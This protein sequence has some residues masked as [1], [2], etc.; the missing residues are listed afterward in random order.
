MRNQWDSKK[1]KLLDAFSSFDKR[2]PM[3]AE[4]MHNGFIV[5]DDMFID[6]I[7]EGFENKFFISVKNKK[8]LVKD[9]SYNKRRKQKSLA[10]YCEYAGSNFIQLSG[11][12]PCQK[13]YLGMYDNR[14]VVLCEDLFSECIFRPFKELHQSSAGTDLG[15]KEYTY[16]DVLYVLEKKEKLVGSEFSD[17]K[18]KFW[19]MFLFD[20]ILGNRDRHEGN[21]G[22]VKKNSKT[23]LAPIF[24][25][26]SSLFPDVDL[27]D[28]KHYQFVK[29]RVHKIPASQFKMWKPG[30]VDRP[31]RTNFYEIIT[32]FHK[33]FKDELT[34]VGQIDYQTIAADSIV[35]VPEE[36]AEWFRVIIECR[37]RVL[38]LGEDFDNVWED[39]ARRYHYD[40]H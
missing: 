30:I 11:L 3:T 6:S 26:G 38:I 12:L 20:A 39:V 14:H 1:L 16:E 25:N 31:M 4:K 24:D 22:F 10:P 17:F 28:W 21:W 33:I 34:R 23:T 13:T 29:D 35:D 15:N 2:I 18:E 7:G 8:F 36:V 27:S 37:F 19:F 5:T 40:L 9:S 32:E